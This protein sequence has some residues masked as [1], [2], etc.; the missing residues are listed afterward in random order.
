M[1]EMGAQCNAYTRGIGLFER[2]R[3]RYPWLVAYS[4]RSRL[5]DVTR[6]LDAI[7]RS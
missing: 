2:F 5:L 6:P 1:R 3:K 4:Q 7:V